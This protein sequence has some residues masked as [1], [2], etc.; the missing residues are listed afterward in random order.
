MYILFL[1]Q[2]VLCISGQFLFPLCYGKKVQINE[3]FIVYM[4][5]LTY[6]GITYYFLCYKAFNGFSILYSKQRYGHRS[7]SLTP[8]T[9]AMLCYVMYRIVVSTKTVQHQVQ[10]M[11]SVAQCYVTLRLHH[12]C[13]FFTRI[14]QGENCRSVLG[15]TILFKGQ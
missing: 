1:Y 12:Q 9:S 13:K 11:R 10:L 3:I 5:I 6:S 15:K 2:A 14:V 7:T 4:L 8:I